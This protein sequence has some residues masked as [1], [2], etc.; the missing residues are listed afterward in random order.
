MWYL[1]CLE[2][3]HT[4]Y[5]GYDARPK[6][7]ARIQYAGMWAM[8]MIPDKLGVDSIQQIV[9]ILFTGITIMGTVIGE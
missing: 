4:W 6:R 9:G 3:T 2:I 7:P 5:L 8:P 1:V